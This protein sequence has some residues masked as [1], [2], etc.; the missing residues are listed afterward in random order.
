M[1]KNAKVSLSSVRSF[2]LSVNKARD[3][4][5]KFDKGINC[6]NAFCNYLKQL[7]KD[8]KKGS[9]DIK[10]AQN[11]LEEKINVIKQTLARFTAQLNELKEQLSFLEIEI[12]TISRT[13][14]YSSTNE[15]SEKFDSTD[16]S[17]TS[18]TQGSRVVDNPEYL[19]ISEQ[20]KEI[21]EDIRT[22]ELEMFPFQQKLDHANSIKNQITAQI[23]LM[24]S[25]IF[26]LENKITTCEKLR[27]ELEELK[28]SNFNKSTRASDNLQKIENIIS[29]YLSINMDYKNTVPRNV[30]TLFK[31]HNIR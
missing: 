21:Q 15:S 2:R 23:D 6:I 31:E 14:E 22:T 1:I 28:S 17:G 19:H 29:K 20:I 25:V 9:S 26:S 3:Y 4:S 5:S 24:N 11:N 16:T 10:I 13:I 12:S 30:S 8:L 27:T 7:N 18:N